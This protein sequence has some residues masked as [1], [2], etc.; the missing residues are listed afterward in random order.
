MSELRLRPIT[1]ADA[2]DERIIGWHTDPEGYRLMLE[3]PRSPGE[4][5]SA[6]REWAAAWER[7]G[8]SY[9]VAERDGEPI[10][11]GGLRQFTHKGV[12]YLNLYYRLDPSERGRG[13]AREIARAATAFGVEHRP[14]LPIVARIG[15]I[16]EPSLRT[17]RSAGMI[18]LGEFRLPHDPPGEASILFN[19]PHV[20]TGPPTDAERSELL[21]LWV[22]VNDAG[23]AVGFEAGAPRAEVA[24]VLDEHLSSDMLVRLVHP[25]MD[26]FY[27]PS[28][29]GALIGFGFLRRPTAA[30]ARHRVSLLRVMTDPALRGRWFGRLLV[31]ALHG[32]ARRSGAE[33]AEIDYRGGTGLGEFYEQCGYAES[34]RVVDGLKFSFG[35]RDDVS[36]TCRLTPPVQQRR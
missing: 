7:D 17:A 9:W 2:A 19:A 32:Q 5:V 3:E 4:A 31:A 25:T 14:D 23:G 36:M 29:Y 34:G 33:I 20:V 1:D 28:S 21:D 24:R 27:D 35:Y 10:G 26:T 16:N 18:E 12:G 8:L 11:I 30:V 22:A 13:T 15:P 6:I